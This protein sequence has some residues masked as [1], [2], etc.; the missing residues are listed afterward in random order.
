VTEVSAQ[1]RRIRPVTVAIGVVIAA[2][3]VMWIYAWFFAPR[4][5]VDRFDDPAWSARAEGVCAATRE[6]VD[7]LPSADSFKD[8]EPKAEA[9][10]QRAGVVDQATALLA[11]QFTTL[12]SPGPTDAKAQIGVPLWL[13]DWEGYLQS[14]REH[15]ERLRSGLDQPFRVLEEGGA[16]VTLRMDAFAKTNGFPSCIVPDDI[17]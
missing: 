13:A 1:R 4:G 3:A 6:R 12:Q 8:I 16:P 7:A 17:G 14:R 5:N 11:A 15:A 9:L 2:I 10:R